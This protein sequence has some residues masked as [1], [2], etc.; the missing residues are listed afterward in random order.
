MQVVRGKRL[1]EFEAAA[2]E[3]LVAQHDR[4][5]IDVGTGDARTA[6]RIAK[7]HRNGW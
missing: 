7:S 1:V 2:L 3:A 4:V 6:Y 5:L